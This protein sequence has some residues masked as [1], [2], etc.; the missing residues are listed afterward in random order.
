M[1]ASELITVL[2]QSIKD[3]GDSDVLIQE[4]SGVKNI[5][6]VNEA[7]LQSKLAPSVA[8]IQAPQVVL[9]PG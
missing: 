8:V 4:A 3:I 1:K 5:V 6:A 2:Q 7:G 9:F